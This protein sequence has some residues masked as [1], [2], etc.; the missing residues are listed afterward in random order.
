VKAW[1]D[2]VDE[3]IAFIRGWTAGANSQ[4]AGAIADVIQRRDQGTSLKTLSKKMS[5]G[6]YSPFRSHDKQEAER[7]RRRAIVLVRGEILGHSPTA[8]KAQTDQ[9]QSAQLDTQLNQILGQARQQIINET[10]Q[11]WTQFCT[12]T[13]MFLQNREIWVR[14]DA[15]SG[16]QTFAFGYD[17][18]Q[19]R[20]RL[21][22][23]NVMGNYIDI[24]VQVNHLP[25]T[26]YDAVQANLGAIPGTAL[27]QAHPVVTTQLTGCSYVYEIN[28][29]TMQAA[30]VWPAGTISPTL[31]A[32]TLD[33]NADF[34]APNGG[35]VQVFGARTANDATGYLH[36]GTWTYVVAVYS[37]A[38]QIHV[39]QV[40]Q[41][42][43]S[44]ITYTRV[45]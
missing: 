23:Q 4:Y 28:G 27:N 37:G 13:A 32:T 30:H 33:A 36:S 41:G 18:T 9:I 39:Q 15:S 35:G 26:R 34:A 38:W 45:V 22:P 14:S 44:A 31:M 20:Y 24:P 2:R 43:G 25:V 17:A 1:H 11:A 16:V 7:E 8:A 12:Q 3:T 6:A 10:Q 21:E 29:G 40:A 5:Q 42:G 19:D